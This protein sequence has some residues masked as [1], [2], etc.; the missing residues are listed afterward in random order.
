MKLFLT[1]NRA[2]G[3]DIQCIVEWEFVLLSVIGSTH[4]WCCCCVWW[5]SKCLEMFRAARTPTGLPT[6]RTETKLLVVSTLYMFWLNMKW[7][8]VRSVPWP[9]NPLYCLL[10]SASHRKQHIATHTLWQ[11]QKPCHNYLSVLFVSDF[12]FLWATRKMEPKSWTIPPRTISH[13]H[14]FLFAG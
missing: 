6:N 9:L 5:G 12:G 2:L 7:F 1:A 11:K 3:N 8:H 14:K 10:M 4:C 13:V